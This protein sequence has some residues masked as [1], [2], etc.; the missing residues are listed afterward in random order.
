LNAYSNMLKL[1]QVN[2]S[3]MDIG[4]I[5]P[6]IPIITCL[7]ASN[8]KEDHTVTIYNNWIFDGNFSHALPLQKESLDLCCSTDEEIF[9]FESMIHTYISAYFKQYLNANAQ[10]T[11]QELQ[12]E[13]NKKERNAKKK[14]RKRKSGKRRRNLN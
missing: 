5:D 10:K 4:K 1:K 14:S 13:K 12:A 11:K 2:Y 8:G 9:S 6:C 7:R 3:Q